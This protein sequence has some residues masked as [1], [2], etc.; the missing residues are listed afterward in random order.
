VKRALKIKI[1]TPKKKKRKRLKIQMPPKKGLKSY[2]NQ[3]EKTDKELS[4]DF[5][6]SA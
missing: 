3:K 1:Q 2:Y 6:L 5:A 4:L